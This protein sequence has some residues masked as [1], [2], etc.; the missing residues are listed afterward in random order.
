MALENDAG[1][2][3]NRLSV[4]HAVGQLRCAEGGHHEIAAT[5]ASPSCENM[6]QALAGPIRTLREKRVLDRPRRREPRRAA[7][8]RYTRP[9][10]DRYMAVTYSTV[11]CEFH[12]EIHM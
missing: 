9:L 6:L 2:T 11:K 8:D 10:H 12:C 5:A 7:R 4:M 1:G 3:S